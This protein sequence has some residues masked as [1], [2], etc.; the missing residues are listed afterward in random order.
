MNK[1]LL[2]LCL[3]VTLC[4]G[5]L[6]GCGGSA[7][8][9]ATPAPTVAPA[10]TQTVGSAHAGTWTFTDSLGRTAQ[11]EGEITRVAP[12]GSLAQQCIFALEPEV[13]VGLSSE[14][15]KG[16]AAYL[17]DSFAKLPVF[18][19][20]YGKKAN[21]NQ[22]SV[23]SAA[24]QV[25]IDMGERK[26]NI[27]EDLDALQEQLGIPVVFIETPLAKMDAAM[28]TLGELLD[29]PEQA[30]K[31]AAYCASTIQDAQE[32]A[33]TIPP[34]QRKTAYYGLMDNGLTTVAT[35]NIHAE[36]IDL[37][38]GINVVPADAGGSFIE[39]NMEQ[40]L[41]WAPQVI[42]LAPNT[43]YSTV[44]SDPLW[45]NLSAI[46]SKQYY[47]IPYGPYSWMDQPPAANRLI[48]IKWLGNLLYPD[49][50]S[51]D[52]AKE[53]MEFY[54]LFYHVELS[55]TDAKALMEHSTYRA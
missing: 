31:L 14:L 48:G 46:Q 44:G 40:V 17:P 21:F 51:Y 3:A 53:A 42:L 25:I 22:E 9:S 38:G 6:S 11:F 33:A 41:N 39:T 28:Q 26:K 34:N 5:I 54:S 29:R 36:V 15:S 27:E 8:P 2:S 12:S 50:F 35:A 52:M 16:E 47:E 30:E 4:L 24:P 7:V 13:I 55:E 43:V 10:S 20:F 19:T 37:V 49:V 45:E 23:L 32:R 1:K 18:G